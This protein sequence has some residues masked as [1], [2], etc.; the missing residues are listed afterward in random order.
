METSQ[1]HSRTF[2]ALGKY[3]LKVLA[4]N[5]SQGTHTKVPHRVSYYLPRHFN[6]CLLQNAFFQSFGFPFALF[7]SRQNND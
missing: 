2:A 7:L 4:A 6:L 5:I 3:Q 1:P